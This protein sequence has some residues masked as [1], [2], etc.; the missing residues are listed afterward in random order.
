MTAKEKQKQAEAEAQA[1]LE[2]LSPEQMDELKD[3]FKSAFLSVVKTQKDKLDVMVK[4]RDDKEAERKEIR[5]KSRTAVYPE[6]KGLFEKQMEL[7]QEVSA[8]DSKIMNQENIIQA[9]ENKG[10]YLDLT[11]EKGMVHRNIADFREVDTNQIDFD[12]DSILT[13]KPPVYVPQIE[14]DMFARRGYVFDAIRITNDSYIVSVTKHQEDAPNY[15]VILTLDQLVLVQDYYF[16]KAKAKNQKQADDRNERNEQAWDDLSDDRKERFL[17]QKNLYHSL[18]AKEKKKISKEEYEALSWQEK[19]KIYKFYKRYRGKRLTSKLAEDSMW[20]SFHKMYE[21]FKD[22]SAVQPKFGYAHQDAFNYW[23]AFRE[24]MKYKMLDIKIQRQ[25]LS[26]NY[27]TALETSFG[28]SNTSTELKDELGVLIKRQSGEK[29][30]PMEVDQIRDAVV[31]VQKIFGNLKPNFEKFNMKFSHTGTRYVFASKALG[32]YISQM[33]TIAVSDKFGDNEFKMTTAHE[34]GHFIDNKI[35][36]LNG[37]RW[38]TDDYEGLAGQIAF[39]FRDN[40]NKPKSAQ[41]EYINATKECFA[42][43]LEQFY[44]IETF[45]DEAGITWSY[46]PMDKFRPFFAADDFV[47]K[48]AYYDKIRPLIIEFFQENK[49]ILEYTYDVDESHDPTPIGN[50][51]ELQQ[52][53][54]IESLEVL[55]AVS[56]GKDEKE[57]KEAIESIKTLQDVRASNL[58]LEVGGSIPIINRP[59]LTGIKKRYRAKIDAEKELKEKGFVYGHLTDAYQRMNM[60]DWQKSDEVFENF[61]LYTKKEGKDHIRRAIKTKN[62]DFYYLTTS[63][64]ADGGETDSIYKEWRELVNMSPKELYRFYNSKEGKEAGLSDEEADNLGVS[65]GRESARWILKMKKTPFKEWTPKMHEWAKKQISFIKRMRGNKGE[66]FD[67]KGNKTRKHTSLLI[68]GHNPN[69]Q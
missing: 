61:E 58:Y 55:L 59:A 20:V 56:G 52:K 46:S 21:R 36:E 34:I 48:E 18:P 53:A 45:G 8:L 27:K 64:Y 50:E 4:L 33:G 22:P 37:K 9:V 10:G 17:N 23:A 47:N 68:W 69:K 39:I 66:L 6:S 35:G 29:I 41:T 31:S 25:D 2:S 5:E 67:K 14:E 57:I 32:V 54:A 38:A 15:Y 3:A 44:G 1:M 13:D 12:P 42:R 49:D 40:M 11:D 63:K 43:A 24:M 26:E 30:K 51:E 16:A 7:G 62:D 28:D 19:E 60:A 65:N